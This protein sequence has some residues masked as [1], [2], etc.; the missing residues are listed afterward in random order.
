MR[1]VREQFPAETKKGLFGRA[2]RIK[3]QGRK[4]PRPL[5]RPI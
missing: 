4:A 1:D 3:T 5:W 2:L